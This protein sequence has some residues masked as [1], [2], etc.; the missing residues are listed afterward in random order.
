MTTDDRRGENRAQAPQA[1]RVPPHNI[2]AEESLLG[3]ML[4]SADAVAAVLDSVDS[5]DFYKPAHGFIYDAIIALYNRGEAVDAITVADELRRKNQLELIGDISVLASLQVNVPSV[6]NATY[7]ATIVAEHAVLRRLITVAGEISDLAFSVPDDIE[8][9]IDEAETKIMRV[10]E[11]RSAES[12][13]Q[14]THI[15]PMTLDRLQEL[16]N[17]DSGLAGLATGYYELDDILVGL[18]PTSLTIVGARPAMGKTSFALGLLSHCGVK[19]RRPALLFSLEMGHLEL[20]QRLLASDARVDAK[21]MSQGQL[22]AADWEKVSNAVLRLSDAPVYIDDNPRL[23]VMDIRA[24]ARRL[25]KQAGD[26]GIVVIDYLQLMSSRTKAENRQVEVAEMSR[27][28]KIL[29]RELECPVVALSQLSRGLEARTDKRPMLSDLRESGSLEQD[30]D[31][32]LFLHRPEVYTDNP[33]P[34][35]QG[36]AEIIVAKHR[37]GPTGSAQLAW[38]ANYARF[39]NMAKGV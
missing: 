37:S 5:P 39:E 24:R 8:G 14:L 18:Q 22:N 3:A 26:L 1:S 23:T 28:L 30:A 4:L 38:L 34:D 25:R 11:D 21:R 36:V 32:V 16:E 12:M 13:K 31:V 19:L 35:E 2:E 20:T 29:A 15:I 9:A 27:G 33:S 7:Y 6:V 17:R 10:S